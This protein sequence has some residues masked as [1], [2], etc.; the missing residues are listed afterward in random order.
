M[1][2]IAAAVLASLASTEP[3][4]TRQEL[5][6]MGVSLELPVKAE[7]SP[8]TGPPVLVHWGGVE[9][10]GSA[11][12]HPRAGRPALAMDAIDAVRRSRPEGE[13]SILAIDQADILGKP[14][15]RIRYIL[16]ERRTGGR[17]FCELVMADLEEGR[18]AI[19]LGGF[20]ETAW[21]KMDRAIR[22]LRLSRPDPR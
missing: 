17:L 18:L 1:N 7:R 20:A 11:M 8:A 6:G 22:S 5:P 10:F 16:T 13:A 12:L 3:V 14:A 4:W 9:Q 21:R 15:R 2:L 19:E